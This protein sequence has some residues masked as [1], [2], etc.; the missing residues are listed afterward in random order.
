MQESGGIDI[1]VTNAGI[2]VPKPDTAGT[3]SAIVNVASQAAE[4][5]SRIP[6]GRSGEPED[7]AGAV[8]FLLSEAA[9]MITGHTLAATRSAGRR[10]PWAD[11]PP[12]GLAP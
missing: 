1:L 4:L 6:I 7:I 9:A 8:T 12:E 11:G 3:P 5:L 10:S 2:N